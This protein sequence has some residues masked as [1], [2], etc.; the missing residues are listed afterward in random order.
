MDRAGPTILK[1]PNMGPRDVRTIAPLG[2]GLLLAGLEGLALF[3]EGRLSSI[4]ADRIGSLLRVNGLIQTRRGETWILSNA[5]LRRFQTGD[6]LRGLRDN[7]FRIPGR[8]LGFLDGLPD[9]NSVR[10]TRALVEG[11]DG[12][13]WAATASGVV[14]IDPARLTYNPVSPKIA[15]RSLETG[16][17]RYL[18]PDA[19]TL[20][21]GS[22]N[23]TIGFAALR[24]RIPERVQVRYQLEGQDRGWINPGLRRQ[25]FYTNLVRPIP[26]PC[27]RGEREWHLE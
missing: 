1:I 15:I 14:W 20:P 23:V 11:G 12:R 10:T 27:H 26:V 9:S 4:A 2:D 17:W 19:L 5:G 24:L 3:R 7:Q 8:T 22:S 16:N 13:L 21:A 18:D 25:A 6:L